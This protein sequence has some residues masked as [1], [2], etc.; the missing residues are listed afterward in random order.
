MT[1]ARAIAERRAINDAAAQK[2]G[3]YKDLPPIENGNRRIIDGLVHVGPQGAPKVSPKLSNAQAMQKFKDMGVPEGSRAWNNLKASGDAPALVELFPA[4][5]K[6]LGAGVEGMGVALP[7][8]KALRIQHGGGQPLL[9]ADV[10]KVGV[11]SD[12]MAKYGS[13]WVESKEQV[14]V[15]A[16]FLNKGKAVNMA[17]RRQDYKFNRHD[18]QRSMEK[19]MM[20]TERKNV[21]GLDKHEYNWGIDFQGRARVFDAGAYRAPNDRVVA[22]AWS[23]DAVKQ[24]VN[25]GREAYQRVVKT[26]G[27][28]R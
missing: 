3:A 22:A 28:R 12:W 14:A 1:R 27:G 25:P 7:G 21:T 4:G 19:T 2:L 16:A 11:Y 13:T 10:G 26:R 15:Q 24:V 9:Q 8:G 17:V 18:L 5:S 23:P 20:Q 6:Y